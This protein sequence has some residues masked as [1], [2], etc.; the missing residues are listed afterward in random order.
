LRGADYSAA[1]TGRTVSRPW[2]FERLERAAR[3]TQIAAPAGSGKTFL[4][5]SW[6]AEGGRADSTAWVPV[7]DRERD[8]QQFWIAVA[9]ALRDT[10]AGSKLVRPLTVAP[11]LDGWAVVE[12]LLEDL[13]ALEDRI[14]LVIDD[15]HELG[16]DA[17]LRQ[18]ELLVMRAPPELRFVLATRHDLRLGLHRLRLEGELTEI[19]A[20][21]LR[22][23]VDEAR[24][25]FAAAGVELPDSALALLLTRTE[26]WAA[27]L[28]LAALS[29]RGHPDPERFAA[30]FS[31]TERTVAE[32]PLAEVLERQSEPVRRLLLRTSICERVNGELADALTGEAGGERILQDLEE[33]G[34]FVVS[35]DARRS[36]FRYHQMFA[37]LLQLELRRSE[38]GE[39]PALHDAAARWFATRG[40]PV[41]AVR[42]AQAAENWILAARLL[43][44][45]WVA[46]D[47]DGQA[48]A[49]HELLTGF[50][51][52]TVAA[53]AELTVLM[54]ASELTA[55]SLAEASRQLALAAQRSGSVAADRRGRFQVMSTVVRLYLA[56][57][58]GDLPAVTEEAGRLLAAVD[59]PEAAQLRLGDDLCALAL[60][61]LGIAEV[62]TFQVN[63]ASRHL[64]EGIALAR[65][66]GRP[67]LE[68]TGLAHRSEL[69][70]F[71][72]LT[73]A[74]QRSREAI[75]FA[76]QHG[77]GEEPITGVAYVVLGSVLVGQGRLDEAESWLARA[78][79][80]LRAELEPAAGLVL[81]HALG[82]LAL[83]RGRDAAAMAAFGTAEK[84]GGLLVT[85][86]PRISPMRAHLLQ[87][88]IRLGE[89]RHVEQA[90]AGLGEETDRGDLR[91]ALA[92][93]RLA[94][95]HPQA[96]ATALRP[97]I[98]GSIPGVHPVWLVSALVQ[99]AIARDALGDQDAAGRA[100]ERALAAAE[101]DRVLF[102]FLVHPAPGLLERHA[103]QHTSHAALIWQILDQLADRSK[104]SSAT[105]GPARLHEPVSVSETRMLRYLPTNLRVPEIADQL[106]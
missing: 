27:G 83:A 54:A 26:G 6:V 52:G 34:A 80:T 106:T 14:V 7:G 31:G 32:Y 67:Y 35:V 94:Q 87:T 38:P 53:D 81:Y 19:R 2:L 11:D 5:S 69:A 58:R 23:T 89:T 22:F 68:L 73:V 25:L 74:A 1:V 76:R 46:L 29:L 4:L 3:V 101:P 16:P 43:S 88:R 55:G 8:P 21:D 72:N 50:P 71:H 66:I 49:A 85:A 64:E 30:E 15:A 86:H 105:A 61:G 12:R 24:A 9:D 39:L 95:G 13:A 45:H 41:Q 92:A 90:L 93:L 78:G 36:W 51:A 57:Q 42:H 100:L 20:A 33:A 44:D 59:D 77:W 99:E 84:L 63:D 60:V 70:A 47:L 18:L 56:R 17:A 98:D 40:F 96:A 28:R 91:N 10:T 102:P 103:R 104:P 79:R 37:E 65:R 62:Y 48:A 97:V 82:M 75:E